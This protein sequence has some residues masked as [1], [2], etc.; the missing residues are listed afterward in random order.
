[1]L[2]KQS[3][4]ELGVITERKA[5]DQLNCT[6]FVTNHG[7]KDIEQLRIKILN[8]VSN[9]I[10]CENNYFSVLLQ[11]EQQKIY[12]DARILSYPIGPFIMKLSYVEENRDVSLQVLLPITIV[13]LMNYRNLLEPISNPQR[14]VLRYDKKIVNSLES[15]STYFPG[16]DFS[17][18]GSGNQRGRMQI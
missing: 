15:L 9:D 17:A 14:L 6:I 11:G 18:D 4:I 3:N 5:L 8:P 13:K 1:M 16:V 12:I 7:A 10:S 2:Y